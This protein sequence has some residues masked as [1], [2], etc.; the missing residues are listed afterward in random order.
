MKKVLYVGEKLTKVTGGA[1]QINKRN[2][3][4]LE[5]E[6]EVKYLPMCSEKFD[7]VFLGIGNTYI[8]L[9]RDELEYNYYDYVFISQSLFGRVCKYVK[10][11][12]PSVKIFVFFHNIEVQYARE[13]CK[14]CGVKAF[15]FYLMT[16]YWEYKSCEYGDYYITLNSRDSKLLKNIY[17]RSPDMEMPTSFSDK[18]DEQ[19]ALIVDSN[20]EILKIDYLFVGVAF[21]ANTEAVQW[22]ISNVMPNVEGHLYVV[23]RGMDKHQ[24]KSLSS[25]VHIYGFVDDLSDFYYRAR[26]IV[27]PIHVGGGMKTK[28]AEALMYGKTILGTSE[29]FEGYEYDKQCMYVCNTVE[30]YV[31]HI[32]LI[33]ANQSTINRSARNLFVRYYSNDALKIKFHTFINTING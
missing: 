18:Y 6:F 24:F 12:Y 1:D 11:R 7:M 30:E 13:Y 21:F 20:N 32:R 22:F 14:T 28:T 27:S 25:R 19:R 16:K 31:N 15:P 29:A 5:T 2:Q 4:L 3:E 10:K 17:G 8:S 23:G 33:K 26:M 9:I